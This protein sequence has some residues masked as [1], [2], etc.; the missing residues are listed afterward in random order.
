MTPTTRT[1]ALSEK[2]SLRGL[3]HLAR[4]R[5]AG[6]RSWH[7]WLGPAGLHVF[8]PDLRRSRPDWC[9]RWREPPD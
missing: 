9:A 7:L 3:V 6:D 1:A 5:T 2:Q 8:W 4:E